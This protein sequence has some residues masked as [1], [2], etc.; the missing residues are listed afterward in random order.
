MADLSHALAKLEPKDG[1][2]IFFDLGA[3]DIEQIVSLCKLPDSN[4][5]GVI[6]IGIH[7]RHGQSAEDAVFCMSKME[8]DLLVADKA[9]GS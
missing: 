3:I 1:D 4:L 7:L 6:F 2:I 9:N 8:L 5:P